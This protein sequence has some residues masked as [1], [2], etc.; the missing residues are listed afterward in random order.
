MKQRRDTLVSL[1]KKR[2]LT[3]KD[4]VEQLKNDFGIDITESYYGMIE[5]GVRTPA[6]KIAFAISELFETGANEIFFEHKPNKMLGNK[7]A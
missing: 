3:Q 1:R 5:Q 2:K 4:V 6:L 7:T